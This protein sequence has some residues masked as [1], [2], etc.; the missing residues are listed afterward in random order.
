MAGGRLGSPGKNRVFARS[1]LR[2]EGMR[3]GGAFVAGD[4]GLAEG[5]RNGV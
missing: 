4:F 3:G 5:N 2:G 1:V